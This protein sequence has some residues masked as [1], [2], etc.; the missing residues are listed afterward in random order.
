MANNDNAAYPVQFS[1]DYPEGPR[2]RL[3]ALVR[4]ILAIPIFIL[5]FLLGLVS[6]SLGLIVIP[7]VLMIIIKKKYPRWWFDHNLEV[8]G[9][10]PESMRM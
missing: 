3:T 4:I 1:V 9:F 10:C 6:I 8:L 2:S 5:S 7:T